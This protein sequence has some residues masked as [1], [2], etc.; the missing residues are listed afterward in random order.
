MGDANPEETVARAV[1]VLNEHQLGYLHVVE[2]PI[3]AGH[4]AD[5]YWRVRSAWKEIYIAN[6]G[7]DAERGERAIADASA[8]SSSRTPICLSACVTVAL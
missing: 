6:A 8:G 1:D 2:D 5:F 3:P 4:N 7:Y